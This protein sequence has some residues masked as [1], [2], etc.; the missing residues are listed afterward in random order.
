MKENSNNNNN[1]KNNNIFKQ[2]KLVSWSNNYKWVLWRTKKL[3]I[4]EK[5]TANNGEPWEK[6]EKLRTMSMDNNFFFAYKRN[7]EQ[8]VCFKGMEFTYEK[9]WIDAVQPQIQLF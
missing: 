3:T 9:N 4:I 8:G 5:I 2:S 1:K 7:T 6:C